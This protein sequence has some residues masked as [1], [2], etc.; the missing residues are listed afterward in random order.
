[1]ARLQNQSYAHRKLINANVRCQMFDRCLVPLKMAA[2]Q[3]PLRRRT[4]LQK[5][6]QADP[7]VLV[8]VHVIVIRPDPHIAERHLQ[9]S[10]SGARQNTPATVEPPALVQ[11]Y[12]CGTLP[13]AH[14]SNGSLSFDA[15]CKG[16]IF[17]KHLL[18][19]SREL[20]LT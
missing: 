6:E 15:F 17:G 7:Q 4:T 16:S 13:I 12:R 10:V 1:M 19:L 8:G 5:N 20:P 18:D 3:L 2:I 9:F 14:H 11:E